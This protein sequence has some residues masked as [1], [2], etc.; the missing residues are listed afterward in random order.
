MNFSGP[1]LQY[2]N[3]APICKQNSSRKNEGKQGER[4]GGEEKKETNL[5]T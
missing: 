4:E 2:G 3:K 1:L 5:L